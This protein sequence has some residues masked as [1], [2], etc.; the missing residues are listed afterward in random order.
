MLPSLP[1][2]SNIPSPLFQ[3][4]HCNMTIFVSNQSKRVFQ[5]RELIPDWSYSNLICP[6]SD[7]LHL[8][9]INC[10]PLRP[11]SPIDSAI[12]SHLTHLTMSIYTSLLADTKQPHCE[13]S[14]PCCEPPCDEPSFWDLL[15]QCRLNWIALGL[16]ALAIGFALIGLGYLNIGVIANIPE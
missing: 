15:P 1:V 2:L 10:A 12:Y 9:T 14:N 5:N 8:R 6:F 16:A 3:I 11:S 4:G 13:D 7:K